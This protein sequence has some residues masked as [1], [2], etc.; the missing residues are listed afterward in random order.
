MRLHTGVYGHRKRVCTEG[1]L[2]EKNPLPH[3][4]IEPVSAACRSDALPTELHPHPISKSLDIKS[5][6][7]VTSLGAM[8]FPAVSLCFKSSEGIGI[9]RFRF[10]N[11]DCKSWNF[12]ITVIGPKIP[13]PCTLYSKT[14]VNTPHFISAVLVM[15][16][17]GPS[18]FISIFY[19][20]FHLQF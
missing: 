14:N 15:N 2:W 3:R 11:F 20:P 12:A 1:W 17:K 19:Y 7:M 10:R 16:C 4:G 9:S 6:F 13:P 18:V 5:F 8:R